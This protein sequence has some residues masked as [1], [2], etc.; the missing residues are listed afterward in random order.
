MRQL[1]HGGSK[2]TLR[3][4][5]VIGM[6]SHG[7]RALVGMFCD[8]RTVGVDVFVRHSSENYL[9][10]SCF[11]GT[12]ERGC[13]VGRVILLAPVYTLELKRSRSYSDLFMSAHGLL[14]GCWQHRRT[15][16][17]LRLPVVG[18]AGAAVGSPVR[19]T[20]LLA[21]M[22]L[23]LLSNR[24]PETTTPSRGVGEMNVWA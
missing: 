17:N 3:Y 6:D 14:F 19:L 1:V 21:I 8:K 2:F 15:S 9:I 18:A 5:S 10:N 20:S 7:E 12:F 24:K 22:C 4:S 11:C 13:K 16:A 23:Q